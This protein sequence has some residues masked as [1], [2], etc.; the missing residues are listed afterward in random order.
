MSNHDEVASNTA[1]VDLPDAVAG[2]FAVYVNGI[3]QQDGTDYRI[4]GRT[5]VFNRSLTP[6]VKMSK[7]QLLR[8]ALGIA[9]TYT[10]HD[11]I[12]IAYDHGGRKRVATGLLPRLEQG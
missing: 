12:D 5:L 1:I 2:E 9:G 4:D 10:K 11:T 7:L 6:E 8:A 3:L